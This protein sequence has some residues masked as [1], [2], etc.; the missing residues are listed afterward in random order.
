MERLKAAT[1]RLLVAS[2]LA[3]AIKLCYSLY[4]RDEERPMTVCTK[5]IAER[6]FG[7]RGGSDRACAWRV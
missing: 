6:S 7:R 5:Y 1:I 2:P 4:R 3:G